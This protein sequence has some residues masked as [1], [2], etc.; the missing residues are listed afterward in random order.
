MACTALCTWVLLLG[1]TVH[2]QVSVGVS[3][4]HPA[5]VV[6]EEPAPVVIEAPPP[7]LTY[8]VA[9][10]PGPEFLWVEGYW[11]PQGHHYRWH[12]G[13]WSRPPYAGAYWVAPYYARGT[14][15]AGYWGGPRGRFDHDHRWDNDRDRRD[16]RRER[17]DER[18][19]R[20]QH[21]EHRDDRR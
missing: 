18:D 19:E 2:A 4:G 16:E 8:V 1:S 14:Y 10:R 20:A 17:R 3:I 7:P 11:Y 9:A 21:R 12:D 13:Y 15:V 5:P 6:I